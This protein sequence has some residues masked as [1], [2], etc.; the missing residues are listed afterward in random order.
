MFTP[1]QLAEHQKKLMQ[2]RKN[3]IK[4]KLT[5]N[6]KKQQNIPVDKKKLN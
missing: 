5:T 4:N 6:K 2:K 3:F 1:K